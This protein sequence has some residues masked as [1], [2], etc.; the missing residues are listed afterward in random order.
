[1][2]DHSEKDEQKIIEVVSHRVILMKLIKRA[3]IFNLLLVFVFFL[4]AFFGI[5][6][7]GTL[8][9]PDL[10]IKGWIAGFLGLFL[11]QTGKICDTLKSLPWR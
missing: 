6:I 8:T 9:A 4:L 1:M 5:L 11:R 3:R 10:V 7:S 2:C